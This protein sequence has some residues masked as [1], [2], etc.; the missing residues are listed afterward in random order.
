MA[1]KQKQDLS[2]IPEEVR[3][4][5]EK[6]R[7]GISFPVS[8]GCQ[9]QLIRDGKDLGRFYSY[10]EWGG[11]RKAVKAAISRCQQLRARYPRQPPRS[12]IEQRTTPF[13][14]LSWG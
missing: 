6:E 4:L 5:L 8:S 3:D 2:H 14:G 13:E 12:R 9:M 7:Y 11:K 10:R 1:H